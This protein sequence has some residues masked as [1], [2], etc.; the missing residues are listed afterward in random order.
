MT[1]VDALSPAMRE[2][3]VARGRPVEFPAN[4]VMLREGDPGDRVLLITAGNVKLT[5][6]SRS[7]AE[8]VLDFRGPGDVLGEQAVLGGGDRSATVESLT[9]VT[10]V[11]IPARDFG[12]WLSRAPDAMLALLRTVERRLRESDRQRL[13]FGSAQTLARVA[14]RLL[15]LA[16][17]FGRQAEEGTVIELAIAQEELAAWSGASREATVKALRSLRDLGVV[18]TSRRRLVVRDL[19]EIARH[20]A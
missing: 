5:K 20:A 14:A 1:F 17:R 6:S 13:E 8:V 10:A 16:Q 15:D 19:D 12:A 4:L 9:P 3:L 2:D 11:S 18:E 7:G